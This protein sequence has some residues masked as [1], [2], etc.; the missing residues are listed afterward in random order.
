MGKVVI[1]FM[2]SAQYACRWEWTGAINNRRKTAAINW[3]RS[4]ERFRM[5]FA[6]YT[7]SNQNKTNQSN[8]P[9][10]SPNAC[11]KRVCVS[12]VCLLFVFRL[13]LKVLSIPKACEK[14]SGSRMVH[15]VPSN[16]SQ[17][18]K[19]KNAKANHCEIDYFGRWK[20]N[21]S[22]TYSCTTMSC[23]IRL[24]LGFRGIWVCVQN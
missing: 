5:S 23:N 8:K 21:H 7:L 4:I 14:T 3:P 2:R 15:G 17:R 24:V 16:F 6:K 13:F 10:R 9:R 20:D 12:H 22:K 11:S 18:I 1:G 19:G